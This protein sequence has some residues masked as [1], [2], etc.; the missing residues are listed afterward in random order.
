MVIITY[1][2]PAKHLSSPHDLFHKP[3][4]INYPE[5]WDEVILICCVWVLAAHLLPG[6]LSQL[7]AKGSSRVCSCEGWHCRTHEGV[8]DGKRGRCYAACSPCFW[9]QIGRLDP[10]E[11]KIK[12]FYL[13]FNVEKE[14]RKKNIKSTVKMLIKWPGKQQNRL[15]EIHQENKM[16]FMCVLRRA[17][18]ITWA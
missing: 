10:Y 1:I 3:A 15:E 18:F 7:T 5:L 13:F 8:S 17:T 6:L 12:I 2:L 4:L 16:R 11:L 9:V 14:L